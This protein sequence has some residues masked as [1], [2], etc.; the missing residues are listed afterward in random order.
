MNPA[1]LNLLTL[2]AFIAALLIGLAVVWSRDAWR[3]RPPQRIRD[4]LFASLAER[5]VD[6]GGSDAQGGDALFKRRQQDGLLQRLAARYLGRL[7]T[8]AGPRDSKILLVVIILLTVAGM[9]LAPL[10]PLALWQSALLAAALPPLLAVLGYRFLVARFNRR[11]LQ[12]FPDAL[13]LIVRAVRAGVPVAKA[14]HSAGDEFA[15]PISTEFRLMG[16]ALRL[17]IDMQQVLEDADR[18]IAISDFSFFVVCL[19]LQR[20][21]GGQLTETLENLS[22][23]IRTRRE[24]GLKAKALTAEGRTASKVIAAVPVCILA[25]LW[26][27]SPDYIGVLFH[28]ESGRHILWTATALATLGLLLINRM[29]KLET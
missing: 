6:T 3:Q 19:Q 18:R 14:I 21:T 9:L 7:K 28:T 8:V 16:D 5:M 26:V 1:T 4:R 13:D 29:S 24:L 27:S 2:A 20:E 17:G 12:L 15:A 25:A 22:Q 23:I 11:F 10:L